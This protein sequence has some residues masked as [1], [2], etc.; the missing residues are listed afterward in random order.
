A[1]GCLPASTP[2]QLLPGVA[3]YVGA[4]IMAGVYA[5]GMIFDPRPSLLVD[6]GTNGEVVLQNRGRLTACATA[7]G[8][9]FEGCGLRSGTRAREGAVSGL[10][11][12]LE[13]FSV[14][15]EIIGGGPVAQ[16][17]G[18]CGSGY[19]D[20]LAQGRRSGLLRETGRFDLE[21]WKGVPASHRLREE[22]AL[23]LRIADADGQGETRVS[24]V[25][26]A[27][28][29]QAKAAIGAG[30]E[31]LLEQSGLRAAE[32]GRVYLAGGFGMHLNIRHAIEIGLLPGF[33]AEQVQVV[34][35]TSLAG[36]VLG[37]LDRNTVDE[38]ESLRSRVEVLELNLQEGFEDRY[39]DQLSLP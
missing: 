38:M 6:I 21:A 12:G 2:L 13:P 14:V 5:T 7:A 32:L 31:I 28:L 1:D 34:G 37:L 17:T 23:A 35:N 10:R 39:V 25:D 8:P 22:E 15:A 9:A 36:A 29:L 27:L 30:I 19:I 20:F 4:D 11:M 18:I 26:V 33:Q 16:A 24:E 3:A